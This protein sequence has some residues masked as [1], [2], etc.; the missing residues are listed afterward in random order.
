MAWLDC[1]FPSVSSII[2]CSPIDGGIVLNTEG[3]V[4]VWCPKFCVC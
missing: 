3:S 2:F 4:L 1:S